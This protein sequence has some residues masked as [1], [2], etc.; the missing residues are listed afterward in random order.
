MSMNFA[1]V[2]QVCSLNKGKRFYALLVLTTSTFACAPVASGRSLPP[3]PSVEAESGFHT[4]A[5]PREAPSQDPRAVY[6]TLQEIVREIVAADSLIIQRP[7]LFIDS[8]G[9]VM[10][11]GLGRVLRARITLEEDDPFLFP[12]ASQLWIEAVRQEVRESNVDPSVVQAPLARADS[13]VYQMI[14]SIVSPQQDTSYTTETLV[15]RLH[16]SRR[17]VGEQFDALEEE[18][19][20]YASRRG[21][22]VQMAGVVPANERFLVSVASV[23]PRGRIDVV[24]DFD[25]RLGT[26]I[27]KLS[28]DELPWRTVSQQESMI[29]WYHYRIKWNNGTGTSGRFEVDRNGLF[30]LPTR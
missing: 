25:Y 26:R 19:R 3:T 14:V 4:S 20:A 16:W 9:Q 18:L 13:A 12:L 22:N 6:E 1:T 28:L 29:G 21:L 23:P 10:Y 30:H 7:T 17:I 15:S 11:I 27:H 8:A 2:H 24:S 5:S